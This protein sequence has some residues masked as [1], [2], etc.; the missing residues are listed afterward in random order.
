MTAPVRV[1]W[2]VPPT[3]WTLLFS[4]VAGVLVLFAVFGLAAWRNQQATDRDLRQLRADLCDVTKGL[5]GGPTPA[6]GPA[7]DRA[8]DLIPKMQRLQ[9]NSCREG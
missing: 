1:R 5:S 2:V 8:R 6:A 4:L 7:G 3:V 9:R